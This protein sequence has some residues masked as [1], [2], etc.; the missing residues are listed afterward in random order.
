VPYCV[1]SSGDHERIRRG[2]RGAGLLD[3]FRDAAIFSAEDVV[4][5]KPAPDLF[6]HAAE[7]MGF[8]PASTVVVEDSEA[9][10]QAGVAAGMRVLG[11]APDPAGTAALAA[12]GAEPF[13]DMTLLPELLAQKA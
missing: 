11:Y 2:L 10:V 7:R 1:A 8:E 5:G 3:R 13:G 4:H 6:L 12:A 9:G